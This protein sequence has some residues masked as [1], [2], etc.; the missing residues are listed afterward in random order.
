MEKR[1]IVFLVLS[2]TIIFGY[3][4]ALKQLGLLPDPPKIEEPAPATD[5][6]PSTSSVPRETT[7]ASASPIKP[8][9]DKGAVEKT[10]PHE[11]VSTVGETVEVDTTLY[12]AKFMSRGAVLTSW[13]LK[14]Y[15]SSA[16]NNAPPVQ[17]VRQGGKFAGPLSIRL[18]DLNLSK[19]IS[20]GNYRVTRDFTTLDD[21]N[22]TGHLTFT[23]EN[24]STGVR[25][26]KQL[27]FHANSYLVDISLNQTGLSGSMQV[28]LGTNFGIVEWGEGFIGSIGPVALV[29]G[30]IKL[31]L[32][33]SETEHKGSVKWA[34]LQDKYFLSVLIPQESPTV[35]VKK[36]GEKLAS[37]SVLIPIASSEAPIEFHLYA[38]PKE[39]DTL[40]A[41]ELGLED[42]VDFG[43]FIFGSWDMVKMVAKPLFYVLRTINDYTGNYGAAIILLTIA[44]KLL[45]VPLQYKSYKSMKQMAGIQP[46]V[47]EIQEKFKEDRERLNKELIKV[48]RDHKVNPV[49]GC[50]PMVLQ[51]PVFVALFNILN[52]AIDLRQAPLW[53][54]INDLSIQDPFY[55][56][57]IVMGGTMVIQQKITPTT[58]DPAQAKMML[59]LPVFMTFLFINFPAGLV[60]YWLTNN[61]LTIGQQLVTDRFIFKRNPPVPV[62]ADAAVKK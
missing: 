5:P 21:K 58:M 38:G 15:R 2:L 17:M 36:E 6:T 34:G 37:T 24:Q 39:Y 14:R 23:Y 50:L 35:L 22:P 26:V 12:R 45:F 43:W 52:V 29:D 53:L 42:T 11:P 25:I 4:Y 19:E 62:V 41:L 55:V 59:L 32:P 18:D 8:S 16:D 46:R 47:L 33:D 54:W 7:S 51:M 1:V 61:T 3:E 31:D 9:A 60:L 48:Y 20:D 30:K 27:T 28:G 56:L 13:E 49:G 44:I 57:P 10:P 40:R